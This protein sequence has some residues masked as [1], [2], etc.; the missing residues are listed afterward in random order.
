MSKKNISVVIPNYNG[1][2]LLEQNLP[3]LYSVLQETQVEYEIII[4]DDASTDDYLSFIK[5]RFP[6]VILIASNINRGFSPTI[7]KGIVRAS[8][9][10]IFILNTDVKLVSGYFVHLFDYFD[11]A[12][13]FG[14]TSRF[15]GTN[16][17]KIHEAAKYPY[18]TK[19][20][21]IQ[22]INFYIEESKNYRV[23]TLYL[24]GGAS[25][26]DRNKLQALGGFDEI[27]APF[28]VEDLDLSIRA[29]RAG[30]RCYYEHRA[31]CRH[32]PSATIAARHNQNNIWV[33]TQRNKLILHSIHLS[34][35]S[36]TLWYMRQMVTLIF[37]GIGLRLKY[38]RA[39]FQFLLKRDLIRKS[40]RRFEELSNG[41]VLSIESIMKK[42]RHEINQHN[43]IRFK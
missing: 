17:D 30:W 22:P 25:L 28:Y 29:W 27:F 3:I 26:I 4:S 10:L 36:K 20:R 41:E 1:R 38:H 43:I 5:I 33:T 35:L 2:S 23:P 15:I 14:V 9:D 8:R 39:F 24:S 34:N 12:D 16:D 18:Q 37:Q 19:T 31:I 40:R 6:D 7:N 42:L 13:T 32:S 11:I 21:K